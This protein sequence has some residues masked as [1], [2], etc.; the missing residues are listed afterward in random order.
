MKSSKLEKWVDSEVLEVI[1]RKHKIEKLIEANRK[2][3]KDNIILENIHKQIRNESNY[4]I[5]EKKKNYFENLV[6]SCGRNTKKLWEV[7]KNEVK[8]KSNK[9]SNSNPDEDIPAND[10]NQ[11]F[12]DGPKRIVEV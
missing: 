1:N 10:F 11:Y 9:Y 5:R 12:I 2:K 8:T 6:K 3:A 7:L 4:L